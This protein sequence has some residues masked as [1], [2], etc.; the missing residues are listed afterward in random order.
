LIGMRK[1]THVLLAI[2]HHVGFEV[3][4]ESLGSVDSN[5]RR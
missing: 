1:H 3:G 5:G 2:L 4:G